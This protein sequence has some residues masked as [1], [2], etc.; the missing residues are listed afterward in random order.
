[1][2][3]SIWDLKDNLP[4]VW[5]SFFGERGEDGNGGGEGEGDGERRGGN[6]NSHVRG[7]AVSLTFNENRPFE[8]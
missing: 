7:S 4:G 1:M 3:Y 6:E 8:K 2:R 5:Q